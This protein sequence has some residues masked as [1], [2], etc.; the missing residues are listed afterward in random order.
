MTDDETSS[1]RRWLI[2]GGSNG[3]GAALVQQVRE[4]GD[5]VV[6]TGRHPDRIDD[7]ARETGATGIRAD[8]SVSEDNAR[9]VATTLASLGGIDVL[10][11]NAAFWYDA[12]IG[13]LDVDAMRRLLDTNV[14][15]MVDLTNRIAPT[16]QA[17]GHGDIAQTILSALDLPRRGFWPELA[18]FA[19]NP[20]KED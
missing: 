8:V 12:A 2:T 9:V 19:T 5:R 20:W 15:G 4:R 14:L 6:F 10:I 17:Q 1:P 13:A 18:V 11:N 7:V 16:M 3:I